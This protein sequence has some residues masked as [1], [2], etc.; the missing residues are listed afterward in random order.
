MCCAIPPRAREEAFRRVD[1]LRADLAA[2]RPVTARERLDAARHALRRTTAPVMAWVAPRMMPILLLSRLLPKLTGASEAEIQ[3]VLSGVPHNVTTEMDLELWAIAQRLGPDVDDLA[4]RYRDRDLPSE[5]Q[6]GLD[7]FLARHGHRTAA[8]IDAG[9]A[10]W[11]EH[12]EKVLALVENYARTGSAGHDAVQRFRAAADE[13]E[14]MAAEI[15]ARQQNRPRAR[16][17][18]WL[19]NRVRNLIGMRELPK[20]CAVLGIAHARKHIRGIG[21]ELAESGWISDPDD[22]FFLNY[23]ELSDVIDGA[24]HH[25]LIATRRETHVR[26]LRRKHLPRLL[27][28]D[29]T[30]PETLLP[31][32]NSENTLRGTSA[33]P[34][35]V[36]GTARVIHDPA[37]ARLQPGEILVAPSTDPGWTPLF[38]TASGLVMEMGGPNS[39]GATVA[40]E[41]GIPAVVGVPHATTA[42][43]D[44]RTITLHGSTGTVDL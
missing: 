29:G 31:Q 16:F 11:S 27:L 1:E 5:V 7:E 15:V 22:V 40:R 44:G 13:A 4:A 32:Q 14:V 43:P 25:D 6:R 38:L 8:E 19:L 21:V 18:A 37:H 41:N 39:H 10:R 36:T 24:D 3:V 35:T 23:E 26:E 9:V 28:S 12:P 42:I 30:E 34:G 17:T 2:A 33:S 20:Y